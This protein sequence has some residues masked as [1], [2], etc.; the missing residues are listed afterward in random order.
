MN[1]FGVN[2]AGGT[3][4]SNLS[5]RERWILN[6]HQTRRFSEQ[7]CSEH[8]E[9]LGKARIDK[10]K[11]D[12]ELATDEKDEDIETVIITDISYLHP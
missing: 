9:N 1:L 4:F 12:I 3:K 11:N 10:Y 5:L 7:L 2:S 8:H 6:N